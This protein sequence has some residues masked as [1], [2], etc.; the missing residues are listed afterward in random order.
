MP[1]ARSRKARLGAALAFSRADASFSAAIRGL[2]ARAELRG[3]VDQGMGPI[4]FTLE[5][6]GVLTM[7]ELAATASIPRS[8]MTG[9]AARMQ[10]R[11]LIRTAPN[12][13]DGRGTVVALA[14]KGR[15]VLPRLHRIERD[16]DDAICGVIPTKDRAELV[17]LLLKLA[18]AFSTL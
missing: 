9:I 6:R 1:A 4:L 17:V 10:Q 15:T 7:S 13:R 3:L 5:Q 18:A 2:L 12:P 16:L 14:P 11:G 8:T